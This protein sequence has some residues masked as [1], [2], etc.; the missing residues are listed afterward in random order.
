MQGMGGLVYLNLNDIL[1]NY[2]CEH[3]NMINYFWR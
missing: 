1:L 2:T 3:K